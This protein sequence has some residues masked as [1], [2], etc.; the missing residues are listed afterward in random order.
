MEKVQQLTAVKAED[1]GACAMLPSFAT[2]G[3]LNIF[4]LL[5]LKLS[6]NIMKES[7]CKAIQSQV[8]IP[9]LG[10][11][12][13]VF[14]MAAF[15]PYGYM[16]HNTWG[17][18]VRFSR[19]VKARVEVERLWKKHLDKSPDSNGI[20][21]KQLK[22]IFESTGLRAAVGIND[23][24]LSKANVLASNPYEKL[25]KKM[26]SGDG[27]TLCVG[28]DDFVVWW[29]KESESC[30]SRACPF[31]CGGDLDGA[32]PSPRD[33]ASA[34]SACVRSRRLC[35]PVYTPCATSDFPVSR[36]VPLAVAPVPRI[37]TSVRTSSGGRSVRARY[38]CAV[39]KLLT[40]DKP[41]SPSPPDVAMG[42]VDLA[43]TTVHTAAAAT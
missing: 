21:A 16:A 5:A 18:G 42:S 26:D 30:V 7:G 34:P 40:E 8:L 10:T 14:M 15:G 37:G 1:R 12:P 23:S 35:I 41:R 20:K 11:V 24:L 22:L 2:T 19:V 33:A 32:R 6:M 9:F 28:F 25:I 27:N 43:S 29:A 38:S 31:D 3:V 4:V 17:R 39:C 13:F 36:P